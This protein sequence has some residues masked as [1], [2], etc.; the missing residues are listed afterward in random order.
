MSAGEVEDDG[1]DE[2]VDVLDLDD[3]RAEVAEDGGELGGSGGAVDS[4]EEGAGSAEGGAGDVGGEAEEFVD[5]VAMLAEE[6]GDVVKHRFLAGGTGVGVVD[7][8]DFHE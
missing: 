8:T 3:V 7:E 5:G 6:G 4:G 1:G 2:G